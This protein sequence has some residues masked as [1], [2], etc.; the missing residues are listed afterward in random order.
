MGGHLY[1]LP[2]MDVI[3]SHKNFNTLH[4]HFHIL[5]CIVFFLQDFVFIHVLFKSM[6]FD[7]CM[8]RNFSIDF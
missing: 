7:L 8:L 6:S 1:F 4:G 5:L 2:N 3:E